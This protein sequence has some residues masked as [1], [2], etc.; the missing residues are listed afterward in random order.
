MCLLGTI[1]R[2]GLI[3]IWCSGEYLGQQ[4]GASLPD[5]CRPDSSQNRLFQ[6]YIVV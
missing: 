1:F 4:V 3:H 5:P 2:G 6:R